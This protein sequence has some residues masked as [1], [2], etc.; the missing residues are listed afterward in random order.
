MQCS[1]LYFQ[2]RKHVT[3]I[4]MVLSPLGRGLD[5]KSYRKVWVTTQILY[6]FAIQRPTELVSRAAGVFLSPV[7]SSGKALFLSI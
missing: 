3:N 7:K 4:R 5:R 2:L 1:F 6:E